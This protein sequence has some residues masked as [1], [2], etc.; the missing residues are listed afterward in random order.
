[1]ELHRIRQ[2]KMA[3]P[4]VEVEVPPRLFPE[5]MTAPSFRHPRRPTRR[6][7]EA[8][9]QRDQAVQPDPAFQADRAVRYPLRSPRFR[10][11]RHQTSNDLLICQL[12]K[13]EMPL[14]SCPPV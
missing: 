1:M 14:A 9:R 4:A 6:G 13:A 12:L 8:V 10:R 7:L 5:K 11:C 2:A 3:S